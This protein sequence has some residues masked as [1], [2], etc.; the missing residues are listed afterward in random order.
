MPFTPSVNQFR[1]TF[2]LNTSSSIAVMCY[3]FNCSSF[4][5]SGPPLVPSQHQYLV[6]LLLLLI[7]NTCQLS[8]TTNSGAGAWRGVLQQ[9]F[10]CM[11]ETFTGLIPSF[12]Q[13]LIQISKSRAKMKAGL[14]PALC[15]GR[16]GLGMTCADKTLLSS[17]A[18]IA[19]HKQ[20]PCI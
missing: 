17:L 5:F 3:T 19:G 12:S 15:K 8:S 1:F 18:L 7:A 14:H 2:S 16:V 10:M 11:G 9:R 13:Q 4:E 20:I 6:I